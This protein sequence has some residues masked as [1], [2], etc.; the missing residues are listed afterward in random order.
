L[1]K[2]QVIIVDEFTG[3]L[4][5]GRRWSDGL[6][7]AVEA[8]ERAP[9]QQESITYATITLQNYFRLYQRLAGMTGTAKTEE[10]EF[11]KV[12]GL[13]VV[14]IPTN[15]KM[16][17]DDQD[18]LVYRN[19][20]AKWR[21]VTI[22]I[23]DL[24]ARGQP[25]LLGTTSIENSERLSKRMS[26]PKLQSLARLRLLTNALDA[27]NSISDKQRSALKLL[28]GRSLDDPNEMI[29][30]AYASRWFHD[31]D[32]HAVTNA[33]HKL[34]KD[35]RELS[36]IKT[37]VAGKSGK[38]LADAA[39]RFNLRESDLRELDSVNERDL[40]FAARLEERGLRL[41]VAETLCEEIAAHPDD[42]AKIAP[43]FGLHIELA[44]QVYQDLRL[45]RSELNEINRALIESLGEVE[46]VRSEF[47]VRSA[48]MDA[49]V[50]RLYL[51]D[52]DI[53]RLAK[54]LE[55]NADPFAEENA[56]AISEIFEVDDLQR[57]AEILRTG[58]PHSVLNAKEHEKEAGI[59]ARRR[60]R[61]DHAGDEYGGSRR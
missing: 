36:R 1:S 38:S 61:R 29:E 24:Y 48:D 10:D 58:A 18:D 56:Q 60:D 49:I 20:E 44:M 11:Q 16:V 55:V 21:A 37:N 39:K 42:L 45:S 6:H 51:R 15:K 52:E 13:D 50:R 3:R 9:I 19:E 12:Y 41:D 57:L 22:E 8:K 27:N 47:R 2:G 53:T 14:V 59:I 46:Q 7:Q 5:P 33:S 23:V 31:H 54:K 17:R 40:K 30:E 35:V 34:N 32:L 26:A 25:T 43:K 28:L 4:M